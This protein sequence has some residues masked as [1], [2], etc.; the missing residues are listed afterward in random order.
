MKRAGLAIPLLLLLTACGNLVARTATATA[1][2]VA[3]A[4]THSTQLTGTQLAAALVPGSAFPRGY[5]YDNSNSFNSGNRLETG[6]VKYP[7]ASVSCS[8]FSNNFGQPG[9]GETAMAG[10]DYSTFVY[11]KIPKSDNEYA[12]ATYQFTSTS[13]ARTWWRAL[14]SA[15]VRCLRALIARVLAA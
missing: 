7:L 9:F 4:A 12:Q 10:N 15:L 1:T 2:A 3:S 14:H 11:V 8:D 13:A 6:P 5:R